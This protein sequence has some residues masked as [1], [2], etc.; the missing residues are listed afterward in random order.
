[1]RLTLLGTGDAAGVPVYGCQCLVCTWARANITF[2]RKPCCALLEASDARI[3]IDAGL[4]DL[5]NR[6]PPGS[7]DAILLT[8]FHPDHVQGLFHLRWGKA[9][10]IAVYCP[11]DLHGCADLYKNHGL[12]DFRPLPKF[13]P[14]PLGALTVTPLPLIH[15][16][17][18]FGYC[19]EFDGLRLAYL[20]DT[21]GLP[22]K[23]EDFLRDGPVDLLVLDCTHPPQAVAPRNHND[24]NLVF[25]IV[26]RCKPR[27][28]VLTH[29][30]HEL[31]AW[32]LDHDGALPAFVKIGR[33]GLLLPLI[34]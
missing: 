34:G 2:R 32:L 28:A 13:Q 33:D 7:L 23:T 1:M 10:P 12:L 27:Q 20:T 21:A 30:G 24:L 6:F 11:A 31:D 22:P 19:I 8:H 14:V 26:E 25:A 15:S 3:L 16:K 18:T 17:P 4:H 29:I 5:A 9:D